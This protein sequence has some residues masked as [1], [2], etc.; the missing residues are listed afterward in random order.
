MEAGPGAELIERKS[1]VAPAW[2]NQNMGNQMSDGVEEHVAAIHPASRV[3]L[4][5]RD[6]AVRD[7]LERALGRRG[8]YVVTADTTAEAEGILDSEVIDVVVADVDSR[9][10][11]DG[12]ELLAHVAARLPF[13]RRIHLTG[14]TGECHDEVAAGLSGLCA[15]LDG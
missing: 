8:H 1:G 4:M 7:S 12:M 9:A 11:T 10:G 15:T 2:E 6:P 5:E 3:L 13:V 14:A